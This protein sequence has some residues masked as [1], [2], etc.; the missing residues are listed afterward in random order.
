MYNHLNIRCV[1][2]LLSA[3]L[4]WGSLT[5]PETHH[6]GKADWLARS[7]NLLRP[8]PRPRASITDTCNAAMPGLFV[9]LIFFNVGAENSNSGPQACPE[10]SLSHW[11]IASASSSHFLNIWQVKLSAPSSYFPFC[12]FQAGYHRYYE[13]TLWTRKLIKASMQLGTCL[14]FQKVCDHHG[15]A[16]G[17]R[18]AVIALE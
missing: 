7:Q 16:H 2:L 10:S 18:Q 8:R 12:H 4:S 3:S 9:V 11:A 13:E 1:S 15:G 17:S 14:M 5:E 6:F